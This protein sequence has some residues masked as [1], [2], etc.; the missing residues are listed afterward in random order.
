MNI[1]KVLGNG[2]GRINEPNISAFLGYLLDPYQDH[3]LGDLFLY[4]FLSQTTGEEFNTKKYEFEILFEQAFTVATKSIVDIVI[5]CFKITESGKENKVEN[6]LQ[7]TKKL[8]KIFLIENKIA[9][10][11]DESSPKKNENSNAK[12]TT[13]KSDSQIN[14]QR[15]N[16]ISR[17]KELGVELPDDSI[18][19]VYITLGGDKNAKN[20]FEELKT[21]NKKHFVWNSQEQEG[22]I[23]EE[24]DIFTLLQQV[25][26][27]ENAGEI[28]PI[29]IYTKQTIIAFLQFIKSGFKSQ[30]IEKKERTNDGSYTKTFIERN[31]A[32]GVEE[33]LSLLK[34]RLESQ[35]SEIKGV[36][37]EPDLNSN[38]V[39]PRLTIN[40]EK[41]NIYLESTDKER[42]CLNM[43]YVRNR[44]PQSF[45]TLEALAK[46][47]NR[48]VSKQ[49]AP[50]AYV[51][52]YNAG[53]IKFDDVESIKQ[54]LTNAILQLNS[55]D[56]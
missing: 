22:D 4:R 27:D 25:V 36:I 12:T 6:I 50:D 15:T 37:S 31:I 42:E 34:Q 45:E 5:L 53:S 10:V 29:N 26:K 28:E 33:K 13:E 2:D 23:Q 7:S 30:L 55:L 8:E 40:F 51:R 17:L 16:T 43:I 47:L 20:N 3:G 18:F 32:T 41:V 11:A 1:F 35:I 39:A 38:K 44:H 49:N 46:R 24:D 48:K 19:T 14:I 21:D 9:K 56:N 52:L 54:N